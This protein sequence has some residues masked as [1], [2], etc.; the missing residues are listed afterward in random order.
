MEKWLRI[1]AILIIIYFVASIGLK[2]TFEPHQEPRTQTTASQTSS[3]APNKISLPEEIKGNV[4][5][6][7]DLL[8]SRELMKTLKSQG[9]SEEQAEQMIRDILDIKANGPKIKDLVVGNGAQALCGA[10]TQIR[11]TIAGLDGRQLVDLSKN[12]STVALGINLQESLLSNA[13][14]GMN[15]GGEREIK[16]NIKSYKPNKLLPKELRHLQENDI[17]IFKVT[18]NDVDQKPSFD[19]SQTTII[20]LRGGR[21]TKASCGKL[22]AYRYT[23]RSLDGKIL[24]ETPPHQTI[25]STLGVNPLPLPFEHALLTM[26]EDGKR[27]VVIPADWFVTLQGKPIALPGMPNRQ[28]SVSMVVN[29]HLVKVQDPSRR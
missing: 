1:G 25:T 17:I 20:D 21:G 7:M 9:Y 19:P 11:Y 23:A 10:R 15:V 24:Y 3:S 22:V 14:L 28:P 4:S 18:L 2:R 26:A 5:R 29:L 12:P 13:I 6:G 27:T 16:A 8:Y